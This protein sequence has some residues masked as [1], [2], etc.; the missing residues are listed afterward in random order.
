MPTKRSRIIDDEPECSDHSEHSSSS[1]DESS[2]V[3]DFIVDDDELSDS[4]YMEG[5]EASICD[6]VEEE[7]APKKRGRPLGSTNK[8]KA[9]PKIKKVQVSKAAAKKKKIFAKLPGDSSY[10]IHDFS[11]TVTKSG[12]DVG[13]DA[14]HNVYKFIQDYCLKGGVATE[15]GQ[16]A[17][18]H[19]LQG[20]FRLHWPSTKLYIQELQKFVRQLLPA[21][22][23]SYK[24][25]LK[26]FAKNQN[27]SA[28]VGYITKD[29]GEF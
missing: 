14:L 6:T 8:T 23:K 1:E 3:L 4:H 9:L 2:S 18:N 26:A 22:G 11:L 19:H 10:P 25:Y 13:A 29:Q 15:V 12:Q 20:I 24:V 7:P 28:M 27:F 5:E 16:R 17:F 21:K